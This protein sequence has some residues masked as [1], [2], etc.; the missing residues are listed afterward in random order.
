[1]GK[2]AEAMARLDKDSVDIVSKELMSGKD[3]A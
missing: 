1:M 3:P 2:L